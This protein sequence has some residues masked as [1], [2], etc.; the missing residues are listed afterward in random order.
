MADSATDACT[1]VFYSVFVHEKAWLRLNVNGV[2]VYRSPFLGPDSRS[3][4]LNYAIRPGENLQLG[5]DSA[6]K[7]DGIGGLKCHLPYSGVFGAGVPL[8]QTGF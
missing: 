3:G 5:G 7:A 8:E 2:P 4:P 6:G 1:L